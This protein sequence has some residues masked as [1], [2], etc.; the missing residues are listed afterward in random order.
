MAEQF[1]FQIYPSSVFPYDFPIDVPIT[2]P[3]TSGSNSIALKIS[4]YPQDLTLTGNKIRS[5]WNSNG[6]MF[7]S[8]RS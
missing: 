6:N 2:M 5:Y 8:S 1:C 7:Q 4:E 3:V